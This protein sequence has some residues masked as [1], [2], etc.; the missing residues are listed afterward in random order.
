MTKLMQ[1]A[2][3]NRTPVCPVCRKSGRVFAPNLALRNVIA[4]LEANVPSI[5][6]SWSEKAGLDQVVQLA[7]AAT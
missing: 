2:L 6:R 3:H 4:T 1:R 5:Q 7:K